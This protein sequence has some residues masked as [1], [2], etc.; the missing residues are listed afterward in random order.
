MENTIYVVQQL[1]HLV[2]LSGRDLGASR[3]RRL[4]IAG[5]DS[6]VSVTDW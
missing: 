1:S 2:L 5:S 3:I 4:S 6:C